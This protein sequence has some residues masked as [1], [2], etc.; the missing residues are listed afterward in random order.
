MLLLNNK[1]RRIH[2]AQNLLYDEEV[3]NTKYMI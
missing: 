3:S 2:G 1:F